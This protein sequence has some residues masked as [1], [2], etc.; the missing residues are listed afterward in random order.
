MI[1]ISQ[2]VPEIHA[3]AARQMFLDAEYDLVTQQ[4]KDQF[5]IEF[6]KYIPNIP[7][8]DEI[9]YAKFYR[10]ISLENNDVIKEIFQ[11]YIQPQIEI[12]LKKSIKSLE[13]RCYKMIEGCHFRMHKDS[14][15]SDIG[16]IWYLSKDWKWDWGGLLLAV[17]EDN[18]ASVALPEFNKLIIMDHKAKQ[19]P[20]CVTRITSFAKDPRITLVGFLK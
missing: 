2:A 11:N 7:T 8:I 14:Y 6:P 19:L 17:N 13:L 16:F 1:E 12:Y 3:N 5:A 4:K 15:K 10:S 18:S 20:H 9:Y